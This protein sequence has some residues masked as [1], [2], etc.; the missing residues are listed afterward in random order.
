MCRY[1][2]VLE[3]SIWTLEDALIGA[4]RQWDVDSDRAS[5]REKEK[6]MVVYASVF[7]T[8]ETQLF[9]QVLQSTKTKF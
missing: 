6:E 7:C 3:P 4:H 5:E 8:Y 9:R 1:E 2:N